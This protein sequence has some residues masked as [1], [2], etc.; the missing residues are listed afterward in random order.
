MNKKKEK[1]K[2]K[3]LKKKKKEE[4]KRKKQAVWWRKGTNSA[5]TAV[6]QVKTGEVAGPSFLAPLHLHLQACPPFGSS[7]QH[8]RLK[9]TFPASSESN[10]THTNN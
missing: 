3:Q 8:K 6:I 1:K 2:K 10:C 4:K 9:D 5:P 7:T